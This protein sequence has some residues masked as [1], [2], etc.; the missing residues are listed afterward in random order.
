VQK[1]FNKDLSPREMM[2]FIRGKGAVSIKET[3]EYFK[4]N[5]VSIR[6][7]VAKLLY[8]DK[9]LFVAYRRTVYLIENTHKRGAPNVKKLWEEGH[10][11]QRAPRS[12]SSQ[13]SRP[14][15]DTD[16]TVRRIEDGRLVVDFPHDP[17]DWVP[18][19]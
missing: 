13:S 11:E 1:D 6:R 15:R 8:H 17:D 19:K 12:Q 9:I 2:E 4:T 7:A 10:R 16:D 14:L 18:Y 5:S 3:K